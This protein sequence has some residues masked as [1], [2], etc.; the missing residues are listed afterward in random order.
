MPLTLGALAIGDTFSSF[1][2][3]TGN[4]TGKIAAGNVAISDNDAGSALLSLPNAKPGDIVTGCI[5]ITYNGTIPASVVLYGT[6]GGTG[7]DPYL[8]LTVTRGT[9]PGG[10]ASGSCT[11]F[12]ADASDYIGRGAGIIYD[13]TLTRWPDTSAG[14]LADPKAPA[15][16]WA[17]GASH[18]Y[19]LRI[20]VRADSAG[21]GKTATQSF[22]WEAANT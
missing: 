15:A 14:G 1:N 3:V 12:A 18:A 22:T 7:L 9:L 11:G 20:V 17:I 5:I 10:A 16:T 21:Q 2:D 19:R 8:D 6:T 13:D 4:P